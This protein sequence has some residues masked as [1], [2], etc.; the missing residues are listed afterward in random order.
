M[1]RQSLKRSEVRREDER[2][3]ERA[4]H[5]RSTPPKWGRQFRSLF[6]V[7]VKE[8]VRHPST[9]VN[10]L[11][12]PL[13]FIGILIS[14]KYSIGE[15]FFP[16]SNSTPF[17]LSHP[18]PWLCLMT[19]NESTTCP[20]YPQDPFSLPQ[21]R[22][23]LVAVVPSTYHT[24]GVLNVALSSLNETTNDSWVFLPFDD[25]EELDTF[26]SDTYIPDILAVI[27]HSISTSANDSSGG[28][29]E[30]DALIWSGD[31][32]VNYT[33]RGNASY[34][35]RSNRYFQGE[36]ACRSQY[37]SYNTSTSRVDS[38]KLDGSEGGGGPTRCE[39]A[40]YFSSSLLALMSEVDDAI[41]VMLR[42]YAP[43]SISRSTQQ[44][45]A[46]PKV[47]Y[48]NT[49]ATG[50][51][52]SFAALYMVL[53]L[54]PLIQFHL[55]SIVGEEERGTSV[56][57]EAMGLKQ[58]V[59]VTAHTLAFLLTSF[60][61]TAI[62]TL[63]LF[64][65]SVFPRIP[66]H[67]LFLSLFGFVLCLSG[68]GF[69]LAQF[70]STSRSASTVGILLTMLMS[71]VYIPLSLL[72]PPSSLTGGGGGV[73]MR[74]AGSVIAS[75]LLPPVSFSFTIDSL[76]AYVA[77][78]APTSP[79]LT[80]VD[81]SV[82]L[83]ALDGW[84]CM[85]ASTLL[86][87]CA[88]I[89][90]FRL[91]IWR[92]SKQVIVSSSSSKG[93]EGEEM[94]EVRNGREQSGME[95]SDVDMIYKNGFRAL[96][97]VSLSVP[98]GQVFCLLGHNGAGKS[99]LIRIIAGLQ[100]ATCGTVRFPHVDSSSGHTQI[101]GGEGRRI[102]ICMQDNFL[103]PSLTPL[104]HIHLV[105]SLRN[106]E[107][108]D[109][110]LSHA[111][112]TFQKLGM[113][114]ITH[115]RSSLLSGGEKRALGVVLAL[116]GRPSFVI[117]DEPSTGMDP[118]AR[119]RLWS[120]LEEEKR[121]RSILLT[122]H[123]MDEA[124]AVADQKA[125]L[126][127]GK[128]MAVGDSLELKS[129][130]AP[131]F[132][133]L[134]YLPTSSTLSAPPTSTSTSSLPAQ[135]GGE[136][137]GESEEELEEVRSKL[138]LNLQR[139]DLILTKETRKGGVVEF[140]FE[141]RDKSFPLSPPIVTA[142][143]EVMKGRE[144][145]VSTASFADVFMQLG[146]EK[147]ERP[148]QKRVEENGGVSES[149]VDSESGQHQLSLSKH[150]PADRLDVL[151]A[152]IVQVGAIFKMTIKNA[153]RDPV[154]TFFGYVF[155]VIFAL[156]AGGINKAIG[157][158]YETPQEHLSLPMIYNRTLAAVETSFAL[159]FSSPYLASARDVCEHAYARQGSAYC[160][161][162]DNATSTST[163][164]D[165]FFGT[166]DEALYSPSTSGD[167]IGGGGGGGRGGSRILG[168]NVTLFATSSPSFSLF[169][170]P[171]P[172]G[173]EVRTVAWPYASGE[174]SS[175]FFHSSFVHSPLL[176]LTYSIDARIA[177]VEAEVER[178]FGGSGGSGGS[179]GGHLTITRSLSPFDDFRLS[180]AAFNMTTIFLGVG[181]GFLIAFIAAEIVGEKEGE[182]G[183]GGR[184]LLLACVGVHTPSYYAGKALFH[185]LSYLF[186]LV[187]ITAVV[188]VMDVQ[189][190]SR[191]ALTPF[192]AMALFTALPSIGMA[193]LMA[194]VFPTADSVFKIGAM[195]VSV[196]SMVPI[197]T[198][199][200]VRLTSSSHLAQTLQRWFT[201]LDIPYSMLG[202][203]LALQVEGVEGVARE[204]FGDA[205]LT[206]SHFW[207]VE[208]V[209]YAT[210][211]YSVFSAVLLFGYIGYVVVYV[212]T[213]PT[214]T[215]SA[216]SKVK[217]GLSL[218]HLKRVIQAR[219]GCAK[220]D[221]HA[222]KSI[223]ADVPNYTCVGMLGV[224]G[225]GKTT[226][227]SML[228]GADKPTSGSALVQGFDTWVQ[229]KGARQRLGFAPQFDTLYQLMTVEEHIT[230]FAAFKGRVLTA[231]KLN[232]LLSVSDL[233]PHRKK[234]VKQCSG[235]TKR[236]LSTL[237]AL[238]F[239]DKT[240]L[241]DEPTAG[242]DIGSRQI[243]WQL[244]QSYTGTTLLSTHSMEEAEALCTYLLV[245]ESGK[246][247]RYGRKEDIK[248][249]AEQV[250]VV[251][252]EV[253]NERE[254][255]EKVAEK[256]FLLGDIQR[257]E[258][259]G[260]F[261]RLELKHST[262]SYSLPLPTTTSAAAHHD[263]AGQPDSDRDGV[264]SVILPSQS[265]PQPGGQP[266]PAG[267][268]VATPSLS[269]CLRTL[270]EWQEEGMI[271]TFSSRP[272]S[273]DEVFVRMIRRERGE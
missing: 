39:S 111:L 126:A 90:L 47:T 165:T 189:P 91:K 63:L 232:H 155:P 103:F 180:D 49:F 125:I 79:P 147:R 269:L 32:S 101:G 120:V 261:W 28:G 150:T 21:N 40:K 171:S 263:S 177:A 68:I 60:F 23:R 106:G 42:G 192:L 193:Y 190:I 59:A 16:A 84:I 65:T 271:R 202:V 89:A 29:G 81:D 86:Y 243:I 205:P 169:R 132:T 268:S 157:Q 54:A 72:P 251:E 236:K 45:A 218:Q 145:S 257:K 149:S 57:M 83:T 7:Y 1:E 37:K 250:Y 53:A 195:L 25:E 185:F 27:F 239:S 134:F 229:K 33:I 224:N 3:G 99:T 222:V 172:T 6:G 19:S 50:F 200:V 242:I 93:E 35:P 206:V 270:C 105:E 207:S 38:A 175:L 158:P 142:M 122:T 9:L 212:F 214:S 249:E 128:V 178:T 11:L 139:N 201:S 272:S 259:W 55:L 159:P 98:F 226:T 228:S 183:T 262:S 71:A 124:D 114:K 163:A 82:I 113:S 41:G 237:I 118:L 148:V 256:L 13:Y 112:A 141:K 174:G 241:L 75:V 156:V 245:V 260:R 198:I 223:N 265:L 136:K 182:R 116:I 264:D 36:E 58:G 151:E 140:V 107:R 255:E 34:I 146:D 225:A 92:R 144:W 8:K 233:T 119:R 231:S 152:V 52:R 70:F 100:R 4:Q 88:G 31:V 69:V 94:E 138:K 253:S 194:K 78:I 17:S 191:A 44:V 131:F 5:S 24:L 167:V 110:D 210:S 181:L 108:C 217:T 219:K 135:S 215:L 22:T 179:G 153:M 176:A 209:T 199:Q 211:F 18:Q 220:V 197:I 238:L 51:F 266:S 130:Y 85:L 204:A 162:F 227:M 273:L 247:L 80:Y 26:L 230:A 221:V 127:G 133:L 20:P 97:G 96:E 240:V 267:V 104:E 67:L 168:T 196:L 170:T 244:V 213:F 186:V 234:K 235:G 74:Y 10:E 187:L 173:G 43:G 123:Y 15:E 2:G 188:V 121:G 184:R 12:S 87:Y 66:F 252:M 76:V 208:D 164:F 56:V 161:D 73:D 154:G 254:R 115:R 30:N 14:I 143:E 117:L 216:Q 166:L 77:A 129:Q 102:G 48:K 246:L 64:A 95:V 62:V 258:I 61:T 203:I 109:D 46:L 137:R 248:R 160:L